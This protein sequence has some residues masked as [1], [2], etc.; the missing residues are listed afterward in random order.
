MPYN[1][2]QKKATIKWMAAN[3]DDVRLRVPKGTKDKWKKYAE[4]HGMSMTSFVY[5]HITKI[6]DDE[7]ASERGKK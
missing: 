3:R 6:I 4:D 1:E 5:S 2:A 7:E